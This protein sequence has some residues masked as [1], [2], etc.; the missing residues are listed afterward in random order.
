MFRAHFSLFCACQVRKSLAH[1]GSPLACK[2]VCALLIVLRRLQVG[3][4]QQL[5]LDVDSGFVRTDVL[6]S[7][8]SR[9]DRSLTEETIDAVLDRGGALLGRIAIRG[10]SDAH[11]RRPSHEHRRR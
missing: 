8:V 6:N 9:H 4:K 2:V 1:R 3:G 11:D 10:E 7:D 5:T